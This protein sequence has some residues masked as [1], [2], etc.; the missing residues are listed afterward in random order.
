MTNAQ[1]PHG[2]AVFTLPV[3]SQFSS[4]VTATGEPVSHD[5]LTRFLLGKIQDLENKLA[6]KQIEE[7]DKIKAMENKDIKKPGE[8]D[9]D[10]SEFN[11]W[12]ERLTNLLRTRDPRWNGFLKVMEERGD[13]RISDVQTFVQEIRDKHPE[14]SVKMVEFSEQ[15][16]S[17]LLNY[18]KGAL[19][20]KVTKMQV[21]GALEVFRDI[22]YKGKHL[23]K[24]K[25]CA[26]NAKILEPK[27]ASSE[28]EVDKSLTD[29]RWD[30]QQLVDLDQPP[31]PDDLLKTILMKII[32]EAYLKHMREHYSK[33]ERYDDFE[34]EY[35]NE[36]ADRANAA[37]SKAAE[38]TIGA[39]EAPNEKPEEEHEE[40]Q[41]YS[42]EWDCWICGLVPKR[43]RTGEA[44]GDV[45]MPQ[46]PSQPA[47]AGGKGSWKGKG[48]GKGVKC[49]GCGGPHYQRDCPHGA[50]T[51]P[52]APAWKSWFPG[53]AYAPPSPETW[54]S[55]MP[56]KGGKGKGGK[57]KG[58][59]KGKGLGAMG[60]THG[61]ALGAMS[62]GGFIGA[63]N[64]AEQHVDSD[65]GSSDDAEWLTE[66][67]KEN[68]VP[69]VTT[70]GSGGQSK[71]P[72]TRCVPKSHGAA[73][74]SDTGC[75]GGGF[76]QAKNLRRRARPFNPVVPPIPMGME[77]MENVTSD[78][79]E[80]E[81]TLRADE[82]P[83]LPKKPPV[84][85]KNSFN[86][87]EGSDDENY[88]I[89]KKPII[90]EI[91]EI[92]RVKKSQGQTR[93]RRQLRRRKGRE[94]AGDDAD[95]EL[96]DEA[97]AAVEQETHNVTM[98]GQA[99]YVYTEDESV[100]GPASQ[101]ECLKH[102]MVPNYAPVEE[103]YMTSSQKADAITRRL[104]ARD[105]VNNATNDDNGMEDIENGTAEQLFG[106][107]IC[108]V[109]REFKEEADR[110]R[111]MCMAERMELESRQPTSEKGP[112]VLLTDKPVEAPTGPCWAFSDPSVQLNE[113]GMTTGGWQLLS[114]AV[115]SGAAETVIPHRLVSQYPIRE[116]E[117]SKAGMCYASATNQ[118][119]P[120]LGEQ[121][122][123]LVTREGSLRGM[124][125]QAAPVS[126][127]LGSVKRMCAN[128]HRVVFDD[129]GSYIQNKLT[130]E[131]N[132]L[133]EDNG[134]YML[135]V[136]IV[137]P[138]ELQ[139]H[140]EPSFVRQP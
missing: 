53:A 33:L 121:Q 80:E 68:G 52:T 97:I 106:G 125:L 72:L 89:S 17:Y 47:A 112:P 139:E 71:S 20:A 74:C 21:R 107:R 113:L 111:A 50:G 91:G 22:V 134:N 30:R 108:A 9:N 40:V 42:P 79:T 133:R 39:V 78:A 54:K 38:K 124:T 138:N 126:K 103:Q 24:S 137:P 60:M 32:P 19:Y 48:K 46:A 31:L 104:Q 102:A 14:A 3:W 2:D 10:T 51:V 65:S 25:I 87:L 12:Y 7:G 29:W 105:N 130:G 59:G 119:I 45:D 90:V 34:Q 95:D 36:V 114:M 37:P 84:A 128:N 5:S 18:T 110:V 35:F 83:E 101:W 27:R 15:L 82:Y 13:K 44:S 77:P 8:Y 56:S 70:V 58:K 28:K 23:S 99:A 85:L 62:W 132:W 76:T 61:P 26:L 16:Y 100:T 136:W 73:H 69:D 122:L 63:V 66:L 75:C 49:W 67:F 135:D 64:F 98:T 96:L 55:W 41:V 86:V 88:A 94:P 11:G 4:L 93:R 140:G 57:G 81:F 129:D 127:P 131:I 92:V 117:A 116:T 118:P 109:S 123:P 43:A 120:N 6:G 115:D 1:I